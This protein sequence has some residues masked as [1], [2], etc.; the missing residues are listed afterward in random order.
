MQ[1]QD[2]P[3]RGQWP[4]R[5]PATRRHRAEQLADQALDKT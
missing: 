3:S 4:T 1:Q 2:S 5:L